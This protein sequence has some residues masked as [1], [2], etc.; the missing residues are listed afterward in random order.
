MTGSLDS[1]DKSYDEKRPRAIT[2]VARLAARYLL[3]DDCARAQGP[4]Y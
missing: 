2:E 3:A 1:V 4:A